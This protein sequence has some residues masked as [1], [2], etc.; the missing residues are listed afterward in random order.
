MSIELG[1]FYN[2]DWMG[3]PPHMASQ[4]LPIWERFRD[5]YKNDFVGWYFDAACGTPSEVPPGTPE[6]LAKMWT[7]ITSKRLDVVGVK[8][9]EY[10]IIE[11]RPDAAAGALGTIM[12]YINCVSAEPID[13]R[14][15]VAVLV[16]DRF[17]PDIVP[18]AKQFNIN[19]IQV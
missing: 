6:N 4:D 12:T 19:L 13:D 15:Y 2:R 5:K 11:I 16:S 3:K 1:I 10:W 14:N 9:N 17:D 7:R 18:L 8:T